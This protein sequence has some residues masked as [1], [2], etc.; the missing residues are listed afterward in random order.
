MD[1]ESK[2]TQLLKQSTQDIPEPPAP[3]QTKKRTPAAAIGFLVFSLIG[4]GTVYGYMAGNANALDVANQVQDEY[5]K[6]SAVKV[7]AIV[8]LDR[9]LG[10]IGL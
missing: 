6:A 5:M 8:K 3:H 10:L 4:I 7:K 2:I 9:S 1:R